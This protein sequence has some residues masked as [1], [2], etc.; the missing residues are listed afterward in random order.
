MRLL[1]RLLI[2]GLDLWIELLDLLGARGVR[3]EWKKRAWRQGLEERLGSWENVGRGVQG[4]LRM[5]RSCRTLV[6]RSVGTCPAC[7]ASMR[8]VPGG[9]VGRLLSMLAPR[10]GSATMALLTINVG[11][12]LLVVL[13]SMRLYG[14]SGLGS[15]WAPPAQVLYLL[16]GKWTPAILQG[17]QIWR[18]VTAG[19]L[20]AGL[21]HLGFNMYALTV[22]GPLIE[23][24]IGWRK[25]L[26]VYFATGIAA[27]TSS[28]LLLQGAFSMGAS[29]SLFGLL[30][31]AI[32]FAW[33]R[34]GRGGR[35]VSQQLTQ[36]LILGALMSF[37]PHIDL[38]AHFGGLVCGAALGLVVQP[39]EP[40]TAGGEMALR[41]MT[42]G[43]IL[44][45]V[46]AFAAM[47]LSATRL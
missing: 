16:G 38:A 27:L 41:L 14:G 34:G 13:L 33:L 39:G 44:M 31:F 45:T 30:G 18:L 15:L 43:A 6:D 24:A 12:A 1:G 36:W 29:G 4:R 11:M 22:L 10:I 35:H 42:A 47:M 9:G 5:C 8:G 19:Y 17:G 32:V 46:A 37:L 25:F 23:A 20:H 7:G 28:T 2:A 40:R 26:V 3:W 21:L